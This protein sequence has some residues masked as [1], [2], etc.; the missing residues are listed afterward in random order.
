M[1]FGFL[2]F[3]KGN[4]FPRLDH[5]R[6]QF[7]PDYVREGVSRVH[8]VSTSFRVLEPPD[9]TAQVAGMGKTVTFLA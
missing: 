7:I 4:T 2:F 5:V 9:Q 8:Y 1:A 3:V 6:T